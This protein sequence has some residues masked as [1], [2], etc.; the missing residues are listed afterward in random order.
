MPKINSGDPALTGRIM[1][2]QFR[3]CFQNSNEN[4]K[5]VEEIEKDTSSLITYLLLCAHEYFSNGEELIETELMRSFKHEKVSSNDGFENFDQLFE[6]HHRISCQAD[7]ERL[8]PTEQ[9][10]ICF[11]HNE[12]RSMFESYMIDQG[13]TKIM[14]PKRFQMVVAAKFPIKIKVDRVIKGKRT[15]GYIYPYVC[16]QSFDT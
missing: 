2:Y 12:M 7:L 3:H 14:S 1:A 5:F 6:L 13:Y 10:E 11:T 16:E 15:R 8:T 9:N 4:C